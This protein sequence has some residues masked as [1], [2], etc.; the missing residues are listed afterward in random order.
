MQGYGLTETSPVVLMQERGISN[1]ASV[2]SPTPSTDIKIVSMD[3]ENIALGPN[4]VRV[5][6]Q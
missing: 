3:N 1:F 4:E 5:H 2:G 6:K